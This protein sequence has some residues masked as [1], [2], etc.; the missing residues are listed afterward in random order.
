MN[1]TYTSIKTK[2]HKY[3][4]TVQKS[5]IYLLKSQPAASTE[6]RALSTSTLD[7]SIY[8]LVLLCTYP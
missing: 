7:R 5:K 4:D 1:T 2:S 8:I 3:N 6:C